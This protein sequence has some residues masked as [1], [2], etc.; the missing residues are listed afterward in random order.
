[1]SI[2][3][4]VGLGLLLV[5]A[6]GCAEEG[7]TASWRIE[8]EILPFIPIC[9][10]CFMVGGAE[11]TAVHRRS[12]GS[13]APDADTEDA[14]DAEDADRAGPE[15]LRLL[16]VR[17]MGGPWVSTDAA[18]VTDRDGFRIYDWSSL[19]KDAAA[20]DDAAWLEPVEDAERSRMVQFLVIDGDVSALCDVPWFP[21][22]KFPDDLEGFVA[23]QPVADTRC[24]TL[25]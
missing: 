19:D 13:A 10:A 6:G 22:V 24:E 14:A 18:H 2:L 1:M 8:P 16:A 21:A 3:P 12:F 23:D 20:P 5:L 11:R 17:R 15:A 9:T 7:D 4:R 25:E